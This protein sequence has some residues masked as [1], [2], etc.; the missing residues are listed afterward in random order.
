[1][2]AKICI[3]GP[4][5]PYRGG[6]AHYTFLLAKELAKQ[7]DVSIFTFTRMYPDFLFP[8]R[9]Q[10]DES[11]APLS[12]SA[13][14]TLDSV[15][16]WTWVRTGQAIARENPAMV[17]FQWFHPFFAPSYTGA[18]LV[19][20][21]L[22]PRTR[23]IYLCHNIYPH[24]RPRLFKPLVPHFLRAAD[25]FV[26]HSKQDS[27]TLR[28]LG[29]SQPIVL[30]DHPTYEVFNSTPI[31]REQARL[32]LGIE[33]DVLLFFGY[34]RRYKGLRYLIEAMPSILRRRP[35]AQALIVGEFYDDRS[36][37]ERLIERLDI[38]KHVRIIDRYVPNEE[39]SVYFSAADLVVQPYTAATQ[40][41]ITQIAYGFTRPVIVTRVGG[42]P[43]TVEEGRTGFLVPPR[44]HESIA[45]AA[46]HFF[47]SDL[48][49]Q[50]EQAIADRRSRFG[51][52]R[53]AASIMQLDS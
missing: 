31:S 12:S 15:L 19:A 9:T 5:Y 8:G 48:G 27:Q 32:R 6:I 43:E 36:R 29:L 20:R 17:L 25:A 39:V 42:L 44:D 10:Y 47:E 23:I 4:A 33:G 22:Q 30:S 7:N 46:L 37:Y 13:A 1:M 11:A 52:D 28:D 49:R 35:R 2:T 21:T 3:V 26:C 34:V 45:R 41:G 14:R 38:E 18:S 50:F 51:W 40:S 16:P 53:L 24:E